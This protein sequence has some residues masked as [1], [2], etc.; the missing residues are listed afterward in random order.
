MRFS[1]VSTAACFASGIGFGLTFIGVYLLILSCTRILPGSSLNT[2]GCLS[3]ILSTNFYSN[4]DSN[5]IVVGCFGIFMNLHCTAR[6]CAGEPST[7]LIKLIFN[8][9]PSVM[10]NEMILIV[11]LDPM[12]FRKSFPFIPP[13][14]NWST[15][16]NGLYDV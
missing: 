9:G 15:T 8:V 1:S 4:V 14:F 13:S 12:A 5:L 16:I 7:L 11:D 2:F 3:N 10:F 6:K